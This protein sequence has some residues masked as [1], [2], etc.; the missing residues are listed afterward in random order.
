MIQMLL[1]RLAF[2]GVLEKLINTKLGLA[3]N[4]T[5]LLT[6]LTGR[7][8]QIHME[9][10]RIDL[11]MAFSEQGIQ[12][13]E[14]IQQKPDVLL[15]G[16]PVAFGLMSISDKPA[17]ALFSGKVSMQGDSKT[18]QHFQQLF[19]SL[20]IDWQQQ[21]TR[22]LGQAPAKRI[23][24]IIGQGR[25]W[26]TETDNAIREN[27]SEYLQ[28]ESRILP[29][30]AEADMFFDEVDQLRADVDRLEARIKRLQ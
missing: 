8:V 26:F 29:A 25:Q 6:P 18:G 9:P 24:T 12:I 4:S 22:I 13:L 23:M 28:E 27:V 14:N 10:P 21:L 16:S 11:I 17:R 30:Q 7:T 3:T 1:P 15:S 2:L 5:Q 19:E 20:D